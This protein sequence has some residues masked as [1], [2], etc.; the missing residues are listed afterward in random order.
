VIKGLETRAR[1]P[2]LGV[3]RLGVKVQNREGKEHPKEVE[4]FV[5]PPELQALLPEKP[6]KIPVLFPADDPHRVLVADYVRYTGRLLTLKCDGERFTELPV[7]GGEQVGRCR[8][9]TGKPCA[10]GA[11]PLGRLNV[12]VLDGPV[13]VYQVLI[14]GEQRLADLIVE[15]EVFRRT[16]GRL[17]DIVFELERVPTETQVRTE[18]GKRLP[19]TGWPVHVRCNF[20]VAQ[21]LKARGLD[22]KSLPAAPPDDED[23]ETLVPE[24]PAGGNGHAKPEAGIPAAE[25]DI[26]LAYKSAADL[27]GV[28]AHAYGLYLRAT[29]GVG[30]DDITPAQLGEQAR[31][32]EKAKADPVARENLK[33]AV[34]AGANKAASQPRLL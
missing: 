20:T 10:C 5:C 29:Y 14:G 1:L 32:M 16:F 19:K 22:I 24:E 8:K 15:L 13:G 27:L 4:Y 25:F 6:V 33:S 17:T 34:I 3:I 30:A 7:Q 26:S 31:L 21:A 2:R 9:E 23:E 18:G 11:K 28:S 12:I